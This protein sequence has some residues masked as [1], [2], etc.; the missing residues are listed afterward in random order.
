MQLLLKG[1]EGLSDDDYQTIWNA[2]TKYMGG[3]TD[4][5]SIPLNQK[6]L[7]KVKGKA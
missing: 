1:V 5:G 6:A 3:H 2:L 7:A 4:D